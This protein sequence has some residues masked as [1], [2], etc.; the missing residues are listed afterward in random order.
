MAG[1]FP[2]AKAALILVERSRYPPWGTGR[3][4]RPC[5]VL[6]NSTTRFSKAALGAPPVKPCQSSATTLALAHCSLITSSGLACWA[7]AS[8]KTAASKSAFRIRK[9]SRESILPA[10]SS[11]G[12]AT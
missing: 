8:P 12:Q 3:T 2:A 11:Q 6:L 1:T 10:L 5:W 7:N 4:H 9:T